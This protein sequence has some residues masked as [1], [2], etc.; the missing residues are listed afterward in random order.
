F[1]LNKLWVNEMNAEI[2]RLLWS[3]ILELSPNNVAELSD[4][5]FISFTHNLFRQNLF[6]QNMLLCKL[7]FPLDFIYHDFSTNRLSNSS[8]G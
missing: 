4:E 2:L 5:A 6:Y 3:V 1:C 7:I 8:G